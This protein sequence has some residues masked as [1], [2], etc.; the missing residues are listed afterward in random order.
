M[1]ILT[2]KELR[3]WLTGFNCRRHKSG[4]N[5]PQTPFLKW[6]SYAWLDTFQYQNWW[7]WSFWGGF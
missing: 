4:M 7:L 5:F 3:S 2:Y 6:E 1:Y